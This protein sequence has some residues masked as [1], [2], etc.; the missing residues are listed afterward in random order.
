MQRKRIVSLVLAMVIPTLLMAGTTGK[1]KGKVI[2]RETKEALV[3]ATVSIE[4][5]TMGAAA[6]VEGDYTIVNVVCAHSIRAS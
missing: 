6:D 3:G 1:I 4:G 5:S 2:D